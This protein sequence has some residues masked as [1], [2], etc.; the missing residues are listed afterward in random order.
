MHPTLLLWPALGSSLFHVSQSFLGVTPQIT[1]CTQA[2]TAGALLWVTQAAR[3]RPRADGHRAFVLEMCQ[4]QPGLLTC[5][6]FSLWSSL[7]LTENTP[8]SWPSH[9]ISGYLSKRTGAEAQGAFVGHVHGALFPPPKGETAPAVIDRQ[10]E[11]ENVLYTHDG[12]S[13][14]LKKGNSGSATTWMNLEDIRLSGTSQP[15]KDKPCVTPLHRVP[16]VAKP[17]ET[18][19]RWGCQVWAR[20]GE[21]ALVPHG[22]ESRLCRMKAAGA[23]RWGSLH[24]KGMHLTPPNCALKAVGMAN[25]MS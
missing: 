7:K 6:C 18:G 13:F 22:A 17:T 9:S 3:W 21:W 1:F 2:T 12:I 25:V 5:T 23:G 8:A 20:R 11:K 4:G 10:M 14:S 24:H 19:G 16:G 15:R